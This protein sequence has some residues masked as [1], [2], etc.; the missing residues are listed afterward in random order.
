M[1]E[2][3]GHFVCDSNSLRVGCRVPGLAAEHQL[4]A[5]RLYFLLPMDLL[6]SVLTEEEMALLACRATRKRSGSYIGR[7]IFPVLIDFCLIPSEAKKVAEEPERHRVAEGGGG[8]V[9]G[10]PSWRP[11]LDTIEEGL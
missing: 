5:G 6:Y 7:R 1:H 9:S 2:N 11:A 10:R 8:E 4:E 3:S